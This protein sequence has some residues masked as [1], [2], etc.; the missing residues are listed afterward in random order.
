MGFLKIWNTPTRKFILQVSPPFNYSSSV[1][2]IEL[3]D[4][5][6]PVGISVVVTGWGRTSVRQLINVQC[7]DSHSPKSTHIIQFSPN[8]MTHLEHNTLAIR[9]PNFLKK[10]LKIRRSVD[11]VFVPSSL[12]VKPGSVFQSS[13]D[14]F[15][16]ILC[17][18]LY[19]VITQ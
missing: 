12:H 1:Q 2:P 14:R 19:T 6:V 7:S 3:E 11:E 8:K 5:D 13:H 16:Y 10:T 9:H 15:I 4:A 17:S 18:W